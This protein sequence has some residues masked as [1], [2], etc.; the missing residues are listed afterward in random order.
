MRQLT[1]VLWPIFIIGLHCPAASPPHTTIQQ[2][3]P[4][5]AGGVPIVKVRWNAALRDA[6][7]FVAAQPAGVPFA[8]G[9]M[10]GGPPCM[11]AWYSHACM[12]GTPPCMHAWYSP[13]PGL[14]SLSS[15]G[16]PRLLVYSRDAQVHRHADCVRPHRMGNAV[17]GLV[18]PGIH[19]RLT[20]YQH[21][22]AYHPRTNIGPLQSP[23]VWHRP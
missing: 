14:L 13:S 5:A 23:A 22:V 7:A 15:L 16:F 2:P 17:T 18:T 8:V 10:Y 21:R 3:N 9:A 19:P 12:L 6:V 1:A 11:H 20:A 4:G